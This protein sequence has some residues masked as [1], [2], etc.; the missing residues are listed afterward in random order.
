MPGEVDGGRARQSRRFKWAGDPERW[1]GAAVITL[2]VPGPGIGAIPPVV[3]FGEQVWRA[4]TEDLVAMA[5]DGVATFDFIGLLP[6]DRGSLALEVTTGTGQATSILYWC[7][8]GIHQG[9]VDPQ[10]AGARRFG[11][12]PTP[13]CP[14]P[15]VG[16]LIIPAGAT[17]P[18]PFA[19]TVPAG[20]QLHATAFS[21]ASTTTVTTN[22]FVFDTVSNGIVATTGAAIALSSAPSIMPGPVDWW[23][24]PGVT[25]S[26]ALF[27]GVPATDDVNFVLEGMLVPVG[28]KGVALSASPIIA[29]ALSAR[30]VLTMA[31][32]PTVQHNVRVHITANCAP[33]SWVP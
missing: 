10:N 3:G 19:P 11:W 23:V 14:M 32:N 30:P 8:G 2:A 15:Y 25:P 7:L 18:L 28:A 4:Q 20:M 27:P 24:A 31:Q 9:I 6:D 29:G 1:G 12:H 16:N 13:E 22:A 33:R 21:M 17:G 5:W 26:A